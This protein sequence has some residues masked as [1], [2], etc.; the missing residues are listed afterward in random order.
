MNLTIAI[1]CGDP[2]GIGPE[3]VLRVLAAPPPGARYLLFARS[4]LFER[5][6]ERIGASLPG[7]AVE[8]VDTGEARDAEAVQPG[9]S[10][11]AA[12]RLQVASLTAALDAVLEGRADAI[13]TAPITKASARAAG[14]VFPG[15]TEYLA[16][17]SGASRVAMMLAGPSLR[18][19]PL[20]GHVAL[21]EVAPRLTPRLAAD[22]L[23]LTALALTKDFGCARPRV[24]LAALNPH[25]GEQGM[26]GDEEERVLRPGLELARTALAGQG[27]EVELSGPHPADGLFAKR[28]R[29][30]AVVCCYHDQGLIP[31]KLLHR[32]EA[33]NVTLGLPIVRTSPAHGSALDIAWRGI[34]REGSMRAAMEMAIAMAGRRRGI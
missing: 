16:K 5:V 7:G 21:R 23:E 14:F 26:M 30:D 6:A 12:G 18:V 31:L 9:E 24:A 32:D 11:D 8:W 3:V 29:H 25:A 34:A 1:S 10:G 15:H 2:S 20:T 28:D 27:L 17:R 19:V 33:V 13:C 22:G 4:K